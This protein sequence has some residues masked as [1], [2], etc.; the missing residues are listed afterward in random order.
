MQRLA[1]LL[2]WGMRGIGAALLLL[3]GGFV[4]FAWQIERTTVAGS[5]TADAIVALTGDEARIGEALKLLSANQAGRLLISGVHPRTSKAALR[6]SGPANDA[7]FACCVDLGHGAQDTPGNADET[8]TWVAAH[9]FRSLI[10][11]TSTY[12]MPRSL[13]ELRRAL[14]RIELIPHAVTSRGFHGSDW[15]RHP[16]SLRLL[17]SEYLKFI[18]AAAR[19]VAARLVGD[20]GAST[21]VLADPAQLPG[22]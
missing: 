7:L 17:V 12:H 20:G 4:V 19:L 8:R 18:P 6:R 2:A 9:G 1:R 14:P 16:A 5:R 11:V 21:A 10:V 13:A 3:A 22:L 15:W